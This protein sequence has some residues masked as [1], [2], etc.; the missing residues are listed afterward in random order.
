MNLEQSNSCIAELEKRLAVAEKRLDNLLHPRVEVFF[1]SEEAKKF[2]LPKYGYDGDAGVDLHV[3]LSGD[4]QKLGY[5]RIYPS[6][7]VLLS[8]G[9]HLDLPPGV[10]GRLIHRS[11]TERRHRLRVVEGTID[12]GF[13]GLLYA[14]VANENTF[15]VDV[16]HGDRL[17]Q[18]ILSPILRGIY[19]ETPELSKSDR[20]HQGF[21]STGTGKR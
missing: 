10:F 13:K 20:G 19:L 16:Y 11:S 18:L 1:A 17:A 14:Q 2:G 7:R 6:E 21:G 9:L 8:T 4:D 15:Y 12:N 3:I 5:K